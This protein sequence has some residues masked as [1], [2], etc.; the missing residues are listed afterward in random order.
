MLLLDT[1][2]V[3][4]RYAVEVNMINLKTFK[5]ERRC[6]ITNYFQLFIIIYSTETLQS[7]ALVSTLLC[8]SVL[9]VVQ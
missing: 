7:T 2:Y 4:L 3:P 5:K 1:A 9:H 6:N 8:S